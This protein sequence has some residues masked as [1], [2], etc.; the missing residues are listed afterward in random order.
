MHGYKPTPEDL[1][2]YNFYRDWVHTNDGGQLSGGIADS[3]IWQSWWR[4]LAVMMD[5]QYNAPWRKV[6]RTFLQ[7]LISELQ[8]LRAWRWNAERFI[9]FHMVIMLCAHLISGAQA[10]Q[11]QIGKHLGAWEADQHQIMVE[12][13]AYT[14]KQYLSASLHDKSEEQWS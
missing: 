10:I 6:G 9:V 2:V 8:G 4:D 12:E 11:R 13:T 1:C 3:T 7:A 14:C 5:R